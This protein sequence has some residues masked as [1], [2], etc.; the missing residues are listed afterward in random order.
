[1]GTRSLLGYVTKTGSIYAQYMQFD[2][3]PRWKGRE[4]YEGVVRSMNESALFVSKSKQPT[5][6][7]FLRVRRFLDNYQ[8]ET[9]HS[10]NN[11]LQ[12]RVGKWLSRD[13]IADDEWRY[14]FKRNGDFVIYKPGIYT[15]TIPWSFTVK[16]IDAVGSEFGCMLRKDKPGF[17][18]FWERISHLEELKEHKTIVGW[19]GEQALLHMKDEFNYRS[20][21]TIL[22]QTLKG[23]PP[24][25][26]YP[27]VLS[28]E[29]GEVLVLPH[30]DGGWRQYGKLKL[31]GKTIL[32][33]MFSRKG[34]KR[35]KSV[36]TVEPH[37]NV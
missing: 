34:I 30:S 13:N 5:E 19:A 17:G 4:F 25:I 33:G 7:F 15:V 1:M 20:S 26:T 10:V 27:P 11:H 23:A 37:G 36:E 32:K 12:V 28:L 22:E 35:N 18:E 8:Y 6:E 21:K 24:V 29:Y 9:G 3:D 16:M 31:N 14:L 2:G